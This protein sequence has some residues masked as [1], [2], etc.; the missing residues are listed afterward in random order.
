MIRQ[1]PF[2]PQMLDSH[3][4]TQLMKENSEL[5]DSVNAQNRIGYIEKELKENVIS[6]ATARYYLFQYILA[7]TVVV[8]STKPQ[9][10]ISY[11]GDEAAKQLLKA[12]KATK[13][14]TFKNGVILLKRITNA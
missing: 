5:R 7:P 3:P 2:V 11:Q 4:I 14:R 8:H 1:T 13:I 10:I 12:K 9:Y 6:D